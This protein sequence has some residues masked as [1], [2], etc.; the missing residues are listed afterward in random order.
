VAWLVLGVLLWAFAH[1]FKRLLPGPRAAMGKAGRGLV[2]VLLLASL[3]L[4]IF[5]YHAADVVP[6][7][8]LPPWAWHL[9]NLLM[10]PAVFLADAGRTKGVV[11]SKLRHPMLTAVV[12]WAVAHLLVN[13]DQ[14]SL[15]LFGGLGVWALV[16]MAAISRAEG[17]WVRPEPGPIAKDIRLAVISVVLYAAIAGVHYWLGYPVFPSLG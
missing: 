13:G 7:Y 6:L 1:L 3:G 11:A 14:A 8:D 15:V 9:N 4:M 10:L 12:V 17:P 16:Q 5:G 2:A